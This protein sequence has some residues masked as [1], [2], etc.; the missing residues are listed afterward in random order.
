MVEMLETAN[1][2]NNA[3]GRSL[4]ILDEVGRGTST[5]DGLALAWAITEFLAGTIGCRCLF[6]THYHE[7]T[8]LADLLDGWPTSTWRCG[9]GA[10]R[11]CSCTASCRRDR[12]ELRHSRG[13]AGRRAGRSS[14][15]QGRC[16]PSWRATS[17][18]RPTGKR[19]AASRAGPALA[20][21][22]HPG[23]DRPARIAR[24]TVVPLRPPAAP[25]L[26]EI[27]ELPLEEM[28]PVD[29]LRLLSDFQ[30]R[31]RRRMVSHG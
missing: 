17:P 1:I 11:S 15:G 5:F 3:T 4:V 31:C 2:L 18:A 23:G 22:S 8:E 12:Q 13:E 29:A 20:T 16:W 30:R 25:L 28:K 27:R 9:S 19:W 24:R 21:R 7:L 6:A 14:A 10:S 26:D